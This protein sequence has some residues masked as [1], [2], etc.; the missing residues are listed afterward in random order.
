MIKVSDFSMKMILEMTDIL[1]RG[2]TLEIKRERNN[3]VIVEIKRKCI[4]KNEIK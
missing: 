1:N 2:N 3:V 4:S